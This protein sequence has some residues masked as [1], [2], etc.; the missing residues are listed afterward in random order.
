VTVST[1]KKIPL[2]ESPDKTGRRIGWVNPQTSL[3]LSGI[4]G[5]FFQVVI[6]KNRKGW[7]QRSDTSPGGKPRPKIEEVL[8]EPPVITLEGKNVLRVSADKVR[9][10]G[11]VNH[12][13]R[14]RDLMVFVGDR[15]LLYESNRNS[16]TVDKMSFNIDVPLEDG[17]NYVMIVAR[18][19][20]KTLSTFP[21]FV[22]RIGE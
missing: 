7:I 3:E 14:V 2:F 1:D 10:K 5:N 9:I 13:S 18:Y 17:S 15:K 21:V 22:R 8:I 6:S 11:R 19:D 20:D 4:M 12:P 16:R